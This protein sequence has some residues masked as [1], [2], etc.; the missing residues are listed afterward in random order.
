MFIDI[1]QENNSILV[2]PVIDFNTS[3]AIKEA[4]VNGTRVQLIAK[5]EMYQPHDWWFDKS[6]ES[7]KIVLEVSYFT[8]SKLYVVKNKKTGEQLGF[9]DYQQLWKEFEK[10]VIFKFNTPKANNLWVKLR[11]VLDKGALPTVMQLPVLID[12]DWNIDTDW[13]QQQIKLQ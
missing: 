6:I 9:N 1:A 7:E 5:A 4:I 3:N 12:S 8:L 11:I 13:Y 10:L 2:S